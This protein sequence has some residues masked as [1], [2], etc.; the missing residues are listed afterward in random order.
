MR[1]MSRPSPSHFETWLSTAVSRR[2]LVLGSFALCG[3]PIAGRVISASALRLQDDPFTLGVASGD[4]SSDGMVLWTRLA[5]SPLDGGG[6]PDAAVEVTWELATDDR[7]RRIVRRGRSMAVPEWGHSVHVEVDGLASDRWYWYRFRVGGDV[8][9]VGRTRTLP[10]AGAD[11]RRLRFAFASCQ[12]FE[13]GLYTAYSH[14]SREDLDLVF[15][16][17]DYIYEGPGRD[18]QVRKH[19]GPEVMSLTD[20]RNRLAQYKTDPRL[21]AAHAA[22][23]WVVTW[24]DH[25]VDNNYANDIQESGMPR[26]EFLARRTAAYQAYYEHM[27]LRRRSVPKG[28]HMALYRGLSWGSLASAF[29]LDTR[30]YRTDQPCNDGT[31][32]PCDATFDPNATLMGKEQE[33]WLHDGLAA[34]RAHWNIIPQQIMVGRVNQSVTEEDRY[35]MDQWPGYEAERRRLLEFLAVRKPNNPIV[36]TGDIHSSWVNELQVN[37]EDETS[38]SVAVEFVGTSIASGGD[39]TAMPERLKTVMAN[40]PFLKFYNGQRGYV[41]CEVTPERM[42]TTYQGVDYVTKP[43]APLVT[44]ARFVVEAGRSVVQRA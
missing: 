42:T 35:S 41:S 21:Q 2:S 12:H 13:S 11:A 5:P 9:P 29:V 4:P 18:N 22:F 39:G 23:P 19:T 20:Y 30:Q 25:E 32:A 33:R 1:C 24:D 38:P 28:P 7:F 31:K 6:M 36:L 16:L 27:P 17:G 44:R 10:A 43:G 26:E 14:M 40:N 15:F 8:S 37:S 3:L 34:S